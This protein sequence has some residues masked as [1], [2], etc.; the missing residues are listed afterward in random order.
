MRSGAWCLL[1][2]LLLQYFDGS[3]AMSMGASTR[4]FAA[5]VRSTRFPPAIN[6]KIQEAENYPAVKSGTQ[7]DNLEG[8]VKPVGRP[9]LELPRLEA[10]TVFERDSVPVDP[11]ALANVVDPGYIV[12]GLCCAIATISSLDR[13]MMSVAILPMSAEMLYSD[14]TKGLIAA[15]FTTGYF[16]SFVPAGV[17]A[18]T[19]SPSR[20]LAVGLL[21][22]SVAQAATPA[23]AG[24]GLTTLL[25]CRATM[26]LGEAA[27]FPSIQAIAANWVPEQYRSRY[28]GVLQACFN[29]GTVAAYVVSPGLIEEYGWQSTFVLWGV[30]GGV[31]AAVWAIVGKDAPATPDL[32]VPDDCPLPEPGDPISGMADAQV[33]AGAEEADSIAAA[34]ERARALPWGEIATAKPVWAM[35]AAAVASNYFLFFAI[36]W[37]YARAHSARAL[38]L[39]PSAPH[40]LWRLSPAA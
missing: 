22:W 27:T 10:P 7:L 37:Y 35:V 5:C 9:S 18:A 33:D 38:H 39:A 16:L 12:L 23:A 30:V 24:A 19:I 40:S 4:S 8:I 17:L 14:T 2:L 6:L 20:T 31:L 32:C 11:T 21:V 15:A 26:G 28:W 3:A 34:W 36:A 1:L 25:A 29:F 13:V